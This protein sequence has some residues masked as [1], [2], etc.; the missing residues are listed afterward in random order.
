MSD[1]TVTV[2]A[3]GAECVLTLTGEID[4]LAVYDIDERILRAV[5]DCPDDAELIVID[6]SEVTFI[7]SMG[8]AALLQVKRIAEERNQPT[9]LRGA[10]DQVLKLLDITGLTGLFEFR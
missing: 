3:Q 9:V 1:A 8:L 5:H 4:M 7:D 6:L 10:P 2:D